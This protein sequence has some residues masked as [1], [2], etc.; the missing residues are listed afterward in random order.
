MS[1]FRSRSDSLTFTPRLS[2]IGSESDFSRFPGEFRWAGREASRFGRFSKLALKPRRSFSAAYSAEKSAIKSEQPLWNIGTM[3]P[4]DNP[5]WELFAQKIVEGLVN[6]HREAFSQGR[7]YIAAGYKAK[8]AGKSGGSA[9]TNA[10]RLLNKAQQVGERVKELQAEA[11]ARIERKLDVSRERVGKRLDMA[12][13]LA[14]Q[15]GNPANIVAAEAQLAKVFGLHKAT[16]QYN[17]VDFNSAKSMDE[18]GRL[19][20]QTVGATSPSQ[21]QINLAVEANNLFVARLEQIAAE[22]DV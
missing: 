18:I 13:R 12:S 14:E 2:A 10:S 21:A 22:N 17:P 1:P 16:D 20:L 6:G 8:D 4:L 5:R 3:P 7:A 11:L 19:L 15:Q 9:E